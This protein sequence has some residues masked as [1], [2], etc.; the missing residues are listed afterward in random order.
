[1]K[2]VINLDPA[3]RDLRLIRFHATIIPVLMPRQ[4]RPKKEKKEKG[5]GEKEKMGGGM[6]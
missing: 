4:E 1:M 3:G 6:M 5:K 2:T